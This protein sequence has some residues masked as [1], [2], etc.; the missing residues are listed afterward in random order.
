[1]R[2]TVTN[3]LVVTALVLLALPFALY[4]VERGLL[5]GTLEERQRSHL[6]DTGAWVPSFSIYAHMLTGAAITIL[7]PLQLL[8]GVR[9]RWPRWHRVS[10]YVVL[11]LACLTAIEGLLYILWQGTVG[12][13]VMSLGF[14]IYGLLM[15]ICAVRTVQLARRRDPGHGL[16]AERL[17]ILALASWLYRVHYGVWEIATGGLWSEPDFSGLF[18]LVQV[19]AFYLPY[20]ILHAMWRRRKPVAY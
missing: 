9:R 10:G 2:K 4:A 17:V 5:F 11:L 18:D 19:F 6:F 13:W 12:G 1:M 20:L 15:L 8:R 14:S 16:W 3:L 7:A